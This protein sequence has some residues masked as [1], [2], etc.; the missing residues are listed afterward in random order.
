MKNEII[1]DG[2]GFVL[3][4][5]YNEHNEKELIALIKF[6]KTQFIIEANKIENDFMYRNAIKRIDKLYDTMLFFI[7]NYKK[8]K[9]KDM[10]KASGHEK[11]RFTFGRSLFFEYNS[12]LEWYEKK[13]SGDLKL[14]KRGLKGFGSTNQD[15][16]HV[17]CNIV[18]NRLSKGI[19]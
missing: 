9:I 4:K 13:I 12:Y 7:K 1:K 18:K 6:K 10:P 3:S 19:L 14:K 15:E 17:F 16:H 5:K 2:T 8:M 11:H